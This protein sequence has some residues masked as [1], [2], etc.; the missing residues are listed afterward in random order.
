M[1]GE[2]GTLQDDL[3]ARSGSGVW[4][5]AAASAGRPDSRAATPDSAAAR[6]SAAA[7]GFSAAPSPSMAWDSCGR[8]SERRVS[9][10]AR[11]RP[12][13]ARGGAAAIAACSARRRSERR[14]A[15]RSANSN[16]RVMAVTAAAPPGDAVVV[17]S[18]ASRAP[19][20]AESRKPSGTDRS[21][22]WSARAS[23]AAPSPVASRSACGSRRCCGT[24]CPGSRT[25][26]T[27]SGSPVS[28]S[29]M[30]TTRP[31][32]DACSEISRR[33]PVAKPGASGRSAASAG[34]TGAPS[35]SRSGRHTSSTHAPSRRRARR[36]AGGGSV[37]VSCVPPPA[38][39]LA[40]A[41]ANTG[42]DR[43]GDSSSGRGTSRTANTASPRRRTASPISWPKGSRSAFPRPP[44]AIRRTGSPGA[45][46]DVAVTAGAGGAPRASGA[47]APAARRDGTS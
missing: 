35:P 47:R 10:A 23:T 18:N 45:G 32:R 2:Q 41:P 16:S 33:S 15:G 46:S 13:R 39:T 42:S 44:V 38:R 22:M 25:V 29:A 11:R 6:G 36:V 37:R 43:S 19:T 8:P 1:G 5:S 4:S 14:S 31:G 20:A 21:A 3:V 28:G 26:P 7:A 12:A 27:S 40:S 24:A 34:G 30:A 17:A 9:A